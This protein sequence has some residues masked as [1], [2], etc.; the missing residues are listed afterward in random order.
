MLLVQCLVCQHESILFYFH[1]SNNVA[2]EKNT[3]VRELWKG[4]ATDNNDIK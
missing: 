1:M 4:N 3:L 2:R